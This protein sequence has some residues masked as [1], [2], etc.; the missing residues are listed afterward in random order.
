MSKDQGSPVLPESTEQD[1][2]TSTKD[3]HNVDSTKA[4]E[5]QTWQHSATRT[6][7]LA[8]KA[9]VAASLE[10]DM[11]TGSRKRRKISAEADLEISNEGDASWRQQ[12]EVAAAGSGQFQV[13]D[14]TQQTTPR[15]EE[16]SHFNEDAKMVSLAPRRTPRKATEPS[17][18]SRL[19][20]STNIGKVSSGKNSKETPATRTPPKKKTLKISANGRLVTS[21]DVRQSP[22]MKSPRGKKGRK[23]S[24]KELKVVLTYS[25]TSTSGSSI[26]SQIEDILS[27]PREQTNTSTRVKESSKATHPFFRGKIIPMLDLKASHSTSEASTKDHESDR[28]GSMSSKSKQPIAW[29]DLSFTNKRPVFMKA[30]DSICLPWPP[31][32]MQKIGPDSQPTLN[33]DHSSIL[34]GSMIKKAKGQATNVPCKDD[35][36]LRYTESL[37]RLNHPTLSA[38]RVPARVVQEGA[39][40]VGNM[41]SS[42][43]VHPAINRI[44]SLLPVSSTP[45]ERGTADGN[46]TWTARYAPAKAEE[47]LQPEARCSEGLAEG[48]DCIHRAND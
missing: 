29:K 46:D 40:A 45:F 48:F 35:I 4:S 15:L 27:R 7:V 33:V 26:G 12:L 24:R 20:A 41:G 5:D 16:D 32:A 14:E 10:T 42:S 44:N 2:S 38:L 23:I 8:D 13:V 19:Q 25:K 37:A 18:G 3:D 9:D 39:Q 11:T 47:V 34:Y 31:R 1:W 22:T 36:L 28:E 6:I 21:P 43:E 30:A 17:A